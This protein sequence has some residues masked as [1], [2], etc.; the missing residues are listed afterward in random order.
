[1][2]D[3]KASIKLTGAKELE[4]ALLA[5]GS[6]P[7]GR[8]GEAAVRAG[9]QVFVDHARQNIVARGLVKTGKLRDSVTVTPDRDRPAG[10]RTAFAGTTLFYA[11]FSEFGTAHQPAKSW[12]RPAIDEGGLEAINRMGEALG[13]AIERE[14]AR[15]ASK[16][17]VKK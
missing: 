2:A 8:A 6:V 7:A 11:K 14:A 16:H 13:V 10:S 1:M 15:I 5:I 4:R 17:G 9:A 12:M 3:L